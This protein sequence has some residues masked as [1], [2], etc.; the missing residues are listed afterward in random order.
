MTLEPRGY[1]ERPQKHIDL[2]RE[3]DLIFTWLWD[4]FI[5][6][7][8]SAKGLLYD[9]LHDAENAG[10]VQIYYS[11]YNTGETLKISTGRYLIIWKE[12]VK[13]FLQ[14]RKHLN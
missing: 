6:L 3:R 8:L 5:L 4:S 12:N 7:P 13:T 2:K 9:S 1:P 10:N 11:K 14:V